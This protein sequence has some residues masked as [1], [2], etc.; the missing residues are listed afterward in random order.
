VLG[1]LNAGAAA[2][3]RGPVLFAP[4]AFA[5]IF[6]QPILSSASALAVQRKR[7]AFAD[8]L[9]AQI[10]ATALTISD[11][12]TDTSLARATRFDREGQPAE[13]C[14][15][16]AHGVLET[17]LHNAYTAHA[18]GRAASGHANGGPRMLPGVGPHAIVVA[19]G[20]G[21]D[22]GAL[23]R[24]LGRGLYVQRFSGSVEAAS[25]DFSGVAKS[26]RWIE[27]GAPVR[28]LRETLISGNAFELLKG[29]ITLGS[30]SERVMGVTRVPAAIVDGVTVTAG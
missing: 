10:A 5:E 18:D 11:D 22:E 8:K 23:F 25:G 7:S 9:G 29:A 13:R 4:A 27:S 30:T 28:S 21:G 26:A 2:S 17:Y 19:P 6:V 1:N 24:A 20:D 3:Y 12:P 14:D 16:V 15:I